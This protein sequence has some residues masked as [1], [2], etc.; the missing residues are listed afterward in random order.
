MR[1][2]SDLFMIHAKPGSSGDFHYILLA[3]PNVIMEL[4]RRQGKLQDGLYSRF[5]DR[6]MEVGGYGEIEAANEFWAAQHAAT[7]A[8]ASTTTHPEA[9]KS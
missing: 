8:A 4:M 9:T 6:L 3:N 1:T 5:I 7:V 2:L